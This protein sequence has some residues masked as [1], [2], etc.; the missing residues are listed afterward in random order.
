MENY[1][2]TFLLLSFVLSFHCLLSLY[3]NVNIWDSDE[4][5]HLALLIDIWFYLKIFLYFLFTPTTV[6]NSKFG[7]TTCLFCSSGNTSYLFTWNLDKVDEHSV[8]MFGQHAKSWLNPISFDVTCF[9]NGLSSLIPPGVQIKCP[10][11][12]LNLTARTLLA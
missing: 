12:R 7:K 10:L 9:V 5:S 2:L 6:F 11:N 8:S 3:S 4:C 1:L